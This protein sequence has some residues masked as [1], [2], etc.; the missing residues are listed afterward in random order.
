MRFLIDDFIDVPEGAEGNATNVAEKEI[1]QLQQEAVRALLPGPPKGLSPQQRVLLNM[2][3]AAFQNL[4]RTVAGR[5]RALAINGSVGPHQL[6]ISIAILPGAKPG[7]R[8]FVEPW[9]NSLTT[10]TE[11]LVW[12]YVAELV[13]RV[14][15]ALIA[16]CPA[17]RSKREQLPPEQ[18][19]GTLEYCG[20]LFVRRGR[21][22]LFC[23]GT[24]RAR[25]ATQRARGSKEGKG[26]KR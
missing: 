24:C 9:I 22:K 2:K 10:G 20:R 1:R 3:P 23:S 11:D 18:Y 7:D 4:R 25:V 15:P 8:L 5:L 16:I 13:T 21:A 6:R 19:A 14:G 17:P 12:F 26:K